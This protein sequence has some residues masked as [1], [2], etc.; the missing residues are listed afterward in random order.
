[1]WSRSMSDSIDASDP[2]RTPRTRRPEEITS[3][4][5]IN[6]KFICSALCNQV[7][8]WRDTLLAP[9]G[10]SPEGPQTAVRLGARFHI[11]TE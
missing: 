9:I 4:A 2:S 5:T 6:G 10:P 7:K 1:M 11:L 3:N 8:N